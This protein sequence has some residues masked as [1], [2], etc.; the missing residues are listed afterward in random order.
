[1]KKIIYSLC[2]VLLILATQGKAQQLKIA[3]VNSATIIRE[4]P[5]AQDVQKELESNVNTW[6]SELDKMSKDLQEGL[7]DYQKKKDMMDP[8]AREDKEKS[9]QDLQTRA[10][11]YQYQ[12]F[13]TR[14][15]EAVKMREQ[16]FAPIQEKILKAISQV[17]KEDGFLYVFDKMENATILLY[18]DP[19]FDLTYKVLDRLKRG[20]SSVKSK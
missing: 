2:V 10:R 7:D 11:E 4:L 16:K 15:G 13:D 9:L 6:K 18:A 20:S 19:K 5:E 3:Y 8:K 14:E 1:V 12:K 17:A